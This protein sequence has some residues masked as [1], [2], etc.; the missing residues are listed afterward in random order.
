MVEKIE[1]NL[2]PSDSRVRERHLKIPL[3]ILAPS[4]ICA[5][6]IVASLAWLN[7]MNISIVRQKEII[8][9]IERRIEEMKTIQEEI[10]IL[11]KKQAEMQVKVEGLKSINVNRAKWVD[12]FELYATILPENTWLTGIEEAESGMITLNGMTEADAEVGQLMTRL[13]N[14]KSQDMIREYS[15][16]VTAGRSAREQNENIKKAAAEIA[17]RLS[18]M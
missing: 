5:G 12:A 7:I 6:L 8:A 18:A 9:G 17:V 16:T 15:Y 11:E 14:T 1:I 2:I 3:H 13:F 4:L 10:K